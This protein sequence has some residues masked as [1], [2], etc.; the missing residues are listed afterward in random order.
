ML[1]TIVDCSFTLLTSVGSMAKAVDSAPNDLSRLR[2]LRGEKPTAQM[3]QIRW[4]WPDIKAALEL[5]H[6]LK[7]IHQRLNESGIPI[8]YRTLSLYLGR[9]RKQGTGK[10]ASPIS[11]RSTPPIPGP[12]G[13]EYDAGSS[14]KRSEKR[15]PLANLRELNRKRPGFHFDEGPPDLKKLI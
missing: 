13:P 15:D 10:P 6:S 1:L 3:G 9:V 2:A 7:T 11:S 8:S 14:T 5:G 4:A 12:A